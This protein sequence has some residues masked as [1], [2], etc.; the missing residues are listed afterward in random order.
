MRELTTSIKGALN[1]IPFILLFGVLL[2][3]SSYAALIGALIIGFFFVICD[4]KNCALCLLS[5]STVALLHNSLKALDTG[6]SALYSLIFLSGIFII[7]FAF[8]KKN[9]AF[10]ISKTISKAFISGALGYTIFLLIPY[11]LGRKF[12]PAEAIG[13]SYPVIFMPD[14][15]E[16]AVIL[17]IVCAVI[18]HYL[19]KNKVNFIPCALITVLI[20]SLINYIYGFKL[21]GFDIQ[22]DTY[23]VFPEGD[24]GNT[25]LLFFLSFV[26]AVI[27]GLQT[28]YC[29]KFFKEKTFKPMLLIGISNVIS[30]FLGAVAG[31]L[32]PYSLKEKIKNSK[33]S[34]VFF[35]I[36]L[37]F[38]FLYKKTACYIPIAAAASIAA[39]ELVRI[40]KQNIIYI[41]KTNLK[42]KLIFSL[43]FITCLYNIILGTVLCAVFV[44]V[45]RT[46]KNDKKN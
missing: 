1:Y 10:K 24:F 25:F 15:N 41:R 43:C 35:I 22:Y 26:F 11:I 33:Y 36:I 44:I 38:I 27:I 42:E 7:I 46:R 5:F 14:I 6:V 31:G 8:F 45:E 29:L 19:N 3:I 34:F 40:I 16:N 20:G 17:S 39:Y 13:H 37:L 28:S 4:R 23:K 32:S 21:M 9:N 12:L 30:P 2:G 18:Y